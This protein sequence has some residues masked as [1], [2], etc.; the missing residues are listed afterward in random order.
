MADKKVGAIDV[1]KALM[2]VSFVVLAAAGGASGIIPL[3]ALAALPLAASQTIGPLL[4]RSGSKQDEPLE[5]PA[6]LWWND[7]IPAWQ[8]LCKE[9]EA[10][11]PDILNSMARRLQREQGVVTMQVVRQAFIDAIA[12][13]PLVWESDPQQRRRVAEYIATPL[14]QHMSEMLKTIIEPIR[15]EAALVD[16]HGTSGNTA[17]TVAVLERIY[18]ELRKQG[19]QR[20]ALNS[21]SPSPAQQADVSHMPTAALSTAAAST[22]IPASQTSQKNSDEDEFDVFICYNSADLSAVKDIVVHLKEQGVRPW[23]DKWELIPGRLFQTALEE[24]IK[25]M[26]TAAVFVSDKGLGPWHRMEMQVA[27]LEFAERDCSV[28]PVLLPGSTQRPELPRF[29]KIISWVDFNEPDALEQLIRGI[30]ESRRQG[31]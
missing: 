25:V 2:N 24:Q 21:N 15:Q 18:E 29:L 23:F 5:F 19:E 3:A 6:P 9:I 30:T 22:C 7:T 1:G 11:L 16:I 26:K 14:L 20:T 17:N 28:I 12:N 4:A 10:H 31:K 8:G 13:E 27:L